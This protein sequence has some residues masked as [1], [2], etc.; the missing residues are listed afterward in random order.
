MAAN[1]MEF[2]AKVHAHS[3]AEYLTRIADGIRQRALALEAGDDT[4]FIEVGEIVKLE[5]EFEGRTAKEAGSLQI[6]LSWKPRKDPQLDEATLRVD[7]GRRAPAEAVVAQ[8][9][10]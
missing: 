8:A 7:P 10:S 2:S 5:L 1:K 9:D 4:V 3:A 6:E